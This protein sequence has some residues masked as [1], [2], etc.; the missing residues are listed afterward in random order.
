MQ[1]LNQQVGT[2]Q[3]V[4]EINLASPDLS[5]LSIQNAVK[6]IAGSKWL[7]LMYTAI[8]CIYLYLID[9]RCISCL[10]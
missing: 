5:V 2:S 7:V 10:P 1:D 9:G 4:L 6:Q 3:P 8:C